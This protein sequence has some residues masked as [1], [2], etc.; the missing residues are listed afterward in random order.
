[1]PRKSP[2]I[3]KT[4]ICLNCG[5]EYLPNA[6][7]QFY[8]KACIP[9]MNKQRKIKHYV[10][11]NPGAYSKPKPPVCCV[12]GD[13]FHS[14]FQGKPYCKTHYL[15]MYYKGSPD[16]DTYKSKNTYRFVDDYVVLQ[17]T[18]GQDFFVDVVDL[19]LTQTRTWCISKT[20]YLVATLKGKTI[21]LHR[22]LLGLKN[23]SDIVDHINGNPLDNRRSNLRICV[24][25]EN[26][27]NSKLSINN[28]LGYPGIKITPT[29]K[30]YT[31]ITVDY[32]EIYLGTFDNL[33]D[34]IKVRKLAEDKY[35]GEFAFNNSIR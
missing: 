28:T 8:C 30:Y 1:M 7:R 4:K 15:R 6:N 22:Y 26:S 29:G 13:E 3:T 31:R 21:K 24:Q 9:I 23:P 5:V 20:G 14:N 16:L 33:Q 12:C 32:K 10:K 34:A 19:E 18:K 27:K 11:L 35:Y 17:T 2:T 25:S